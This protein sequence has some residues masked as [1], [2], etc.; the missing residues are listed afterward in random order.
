MTFTHGTSARPVAKTAPPPPRSVLATHASKA[1]DPSA[2]PGG[3]SGED[4]DPEAR[5]LTEILP[6]P[7]APPTGWR[8]RPGG[9]WAAL[10][11]VDEQQDDQHD[12]EQGAKSDVHVHLPSGS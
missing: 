4:R 10:E 1:T 12:H 7:L 5:F 2:A 6:G 9:R 8:Q 3:H 11:H